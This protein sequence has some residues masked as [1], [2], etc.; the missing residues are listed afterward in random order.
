MPQEAYI[1]RSGPGDP[2][3]TAS[4]WLG[5]LGTQT[6]V[7]LRPAA[8]AGPAPGFELG[9]PSGATASVA[10]TDT[11]KVVAHHPDK[12]LMT[13]LFAVAP[14]LKARVFS[15]H[16]RPYS[17]L[18]DWER[19]TQ[20]RERGEGGARRRRSGS[21]ARRFRVTRRQLSFA[22]LWL[23]IVVLSLMVGLRVES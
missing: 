7:N 8:A 2:P 16:M 19:R 18:A 9:L 5:A 12:E 13:L 15:A 6:G 23:G 11:G 4:E 1:A 10:L 3:I 22:A 20:R 21:P 17:S 14:A